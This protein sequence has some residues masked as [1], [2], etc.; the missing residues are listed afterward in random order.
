MLVQYGKTLITTCAQRAAGWVG[1]A[2]AV[3]QYAGHC[4]VGAEIAAVVQESL[5]SELDDPVLRIGALF[6][7]VPHNPAR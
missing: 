5:F 4:G 3:I 6:A 1:P 2:R 7:P